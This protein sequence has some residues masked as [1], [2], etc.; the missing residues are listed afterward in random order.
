MFKYAHFKL[1]ISIA[2]I[3]IY[4]MQEYSFGTTNIDISALEH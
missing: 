3:N 2:D 1:L 4:D